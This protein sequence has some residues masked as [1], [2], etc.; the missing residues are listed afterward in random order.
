MMP[1]STLFELY[2]GAGLEAESA[3]VTDT[4]MSGAL[5]YHNLRN[6]TLGKFLLTKY[7]HQVTSFDKT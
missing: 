6:Y 3:K 7:E 5:F 1:T 2:L 4:H